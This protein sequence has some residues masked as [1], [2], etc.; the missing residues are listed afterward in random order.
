MHFKFLGEEEK[1]NVTCVMC[2]KVFKTA[3]RT[4]K[5]CPDCRKGYQK[6][7]REERKK[8]EGEKK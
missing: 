1:R 2:G 3:S 7:W 6:V 5:R 4:A 8:I